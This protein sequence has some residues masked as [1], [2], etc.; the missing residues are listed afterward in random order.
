MGPILPQLSVYGKQL[1][2]SSE[3]MG[4]ITGFLPIMFLISKPLFGLLVDLYRNYRKT[5]FITLIIT[6][7]MCYA[8]LCL[9]P[10]RKFKHY[11]YNTTEDI[12]NNMDICNVTV[13]NR[14]HVVL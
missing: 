2:I 3:I 6:M 4:T 1:G 12:C 8:L 10:I 13:S 7:A 11:K 5:I 14:N 9:I